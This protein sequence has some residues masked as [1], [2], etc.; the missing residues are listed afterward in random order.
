MTYV[1]SE[2]NS[3]DISG[4]KLYQCF[5]LYIALGCQPA[6]FNKGKDASACIGLTPIQYS[7]GRKV[8]LGSSIGKHVKNNILYQ[9]D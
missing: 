2:H 4:Y 5:N 3:Y 7:L 9:F 1:G 8:K 6:I